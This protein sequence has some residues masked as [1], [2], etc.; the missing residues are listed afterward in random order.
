MGE[1]REGWKQCTELGS[2]GF[3]LFSKLKA[4]INRLKAWQLRRSRDA[5][6][7]KVLENKLVG[8]ED[9]A[10]T[11]SWT[12]P[13]RED[14]MQIIVEMWK[15][16]HK[17]EI[18][19]RQKSRIKWLIEGDKNSRFFHYVANSRRRKNFIGDILVD[20]ERKL[21]PMEVRRGVLNHFKLQFR[22]MME[23]RPRIHCL[24]MQR[25]SQAQEIMLEE[26]FTHEEVWEAISSCDGN[27]ARGP[28]GLNLNF[29]KSNWDNIRDDFLGFLK[30][31]HKDGEIVKH[32]NRTFIVLIPKIGKP[33]RMLDF[34]PISLVDSLYKVLLKVLADRLRRV[35]NSIIGETQMAFVRQRQIIDSFVVAKEI[36]HKWKK[37]QTGF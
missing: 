5:N 17:E 27:K 16:L 1:A 29:I 36:I 20:G 7:F 9:K 28:D 25:I 3:K 6:C 18:Q 15:W 30:E 37:D 4:V 35:M 12:T 26:E 33:E 22:R 24:V 10:Q 21:D 13:L 32:L 31:F 19:W 34:R 14:R 8:V 2:Q 11:E 23:I